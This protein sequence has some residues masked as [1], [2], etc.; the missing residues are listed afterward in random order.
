LPFSGADVHD[1]REQHLH[2]DPEHLAFVPAPLSALV[3]ECLYKAAEARPS[4]GNVVARLERIAETAPSAGLGD[5]PVAPCRGMSI[6]AIARKLHLA[7]NMV[8]TRCARRSRPG[9]SGPG[10]VRLWMR[11]SRG[12]G[13]C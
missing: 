10:P 8:R 3:E 2:A 11:S 4:P 1:F 9:M 7:R 5:P 12:S 13:C 6:K